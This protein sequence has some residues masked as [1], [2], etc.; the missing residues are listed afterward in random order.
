[1]V[2]IEIKSVKCI[3][4]DLLA[5]VKLPRQWQRGSSKLVGYLFVE[6]KKVLHNTDFRLHFQLKKSECLPRRKMF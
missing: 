5:V 3:K 2:L 4:L 6:S 1:M